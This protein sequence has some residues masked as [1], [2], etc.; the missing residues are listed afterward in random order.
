MNVLKSVTL[1]FIF[2]IKHFLILVTFKKEYL[3]IYLEN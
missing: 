2:F 3:H 1:I